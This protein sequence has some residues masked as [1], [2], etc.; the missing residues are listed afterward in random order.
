M[1][2]TKSFRKK[3]FPPVVTSR[4]C[5]PEGGTSVKKHLMCTSIFVA[6]KSVALMFFVTFTRTTSSRSCLGFDRK[7]FDYLNV[8]NHRDIFKSVTIYGNGCCSSSV[9]RSI[10]P[11]CKNYYVFFGCPKV[12]Y[13]CIHTLSLY[14]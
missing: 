14:H 9:H 6:L 13:H 1:W 7:L 4:K 2:S 8:N 10:Q 5:V 3:F 11:S 12:R